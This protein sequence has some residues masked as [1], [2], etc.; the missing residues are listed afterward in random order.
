MNSRLGKG[1]G[2]AMF[3]GPSISSCPIRNS[4]ARAKSALVDPG[5]ELASVAL[6][7]AQ[8]QPD[9]IREH[10]KGTARR[11]AEDDRAAQS[12]FA[13][14]RRR[15]LEECGLP[16]LSHANGEVH[17]VRRAAGS[18]SGDRFAARRVRRSPH[19]SADR[20]A[21]AI[22]GCRRGIHPHSRW[23][24]EPGN[25]LD[26]AAALCQCASRRSARRFSGVVAAVHAAPG[27]V[28]A[29]VRAFERLGPRAD[30]F[31]VPVNRLPGRGIRPAGQHCHM[32]AALLKEARQHAGPPV[33][34]RRA[35]RCAADAVWP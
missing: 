7:S 17:V 20:C 18:G 35:A 27:Q 24:G 14:A 25:D 5:D 6:R 29:D 23:I 34:C 19:P 31:A 11:G 4:T 1:L 21:S 12:H 10:A 30:L 8:P 15:R 22:D 3:T 2:A 28:D 9:Q 16:I 32:V 33:R 26:S 13:R